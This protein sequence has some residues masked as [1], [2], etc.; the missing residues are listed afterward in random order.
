VLRAHPVISPFPRDIGRR[1]TAPLLQSAFSREIIT[2]ACFHPLSGFP[3]KILLGQLPASRPLFGIPSN[4]TFR[5]WSTALW[6]TRAASA[7]KLERGAFARLIRIHVAFEHFAFS[8]HRCVDLFRPRP[9][10]RAHAISHISGVM[11][12]ATSSAAAAAAAAAAA[13]PRIAT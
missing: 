8:S 13:R 12:A 5:P 4:G 10:P 1:G 11:T 3:L 9:R 2:P 6:T 7:R